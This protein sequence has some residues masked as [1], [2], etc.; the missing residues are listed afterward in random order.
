M[1]ACR[2]PIKP[3]YWIFSS[4]IAGYLLLLIAAIYAIQPLWAISLAFVVIG[5]SGRAFYKEHL[6][7]NQLGEELCWTGSNWL[8]DQGNHQ[9]RYL[10][11]DTGSWVTP[12]FCFLR[13]KMGEQEK[14]WLFCRKGLGERLFRELCF[15]INQQLISEQQNN[16]NNH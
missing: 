15:Q 2:F 7:I 6:K 8:V 4:I 5:L 10:E 14:T 12:Y 3:C 1:I 13:F 16:T 9:Q 11:L